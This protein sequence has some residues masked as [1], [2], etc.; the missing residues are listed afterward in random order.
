[1]SSLELT[2]T[3]GLDETLHTLTEKTRTRLVSATPHQVS[4]RAAACRPLRP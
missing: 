2:K 1:M 3:Y 4:V